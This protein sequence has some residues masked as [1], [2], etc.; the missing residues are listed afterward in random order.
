M[1]EI[2][3][4]FVTFNPTRDAAYLMGDF[5]DW[6]ENPLP[7]AKAM[8]LEFPRGAYIEYAFL[9]NHF[10]LPPRPKTFK[11]SISKYIVPSKV[12]ADQ[13]TYY[14]YEPSM[15]PSATLYI[16][17]GEAFYQKLQFHQVAE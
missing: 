12:F 4:R 8:T 7:I 1:I 15:F 3:D 9:D 11:G 13:R 16:Q 14:V 2:Q 17:D 6:D 10:H 5:T